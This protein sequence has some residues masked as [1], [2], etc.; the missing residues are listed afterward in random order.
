MKFKRNKL[1]G[2]ISSI[3][4]GIGVLFFSLATIQYQVITGSRAEF[5]GT[6]CDDN[7]GETL[8]SS[9]NTS[10]NV[11]CSGDL[12]RGFTYYLFFCP[13]KQT[14]AVTCGDV[15]NPNS[16]E[17]ELIEENAGT[18]IPPVMPKTTNKSCGC[19][20]WNVVVTNGDGSK[21]SA[22][23]QLLCSE[24]Q[25]L[26]EPTNTPSPTRPITITPTRSVTSTPTTEPIAKASTT[27]SPTTPTSTILTPTPT[28]SVTGTPTKAPIA[29]ANATV[30]PATPTPIP[31][32]GA[33]TPTTVPP[34]STLTPTLTRT[35]TPTI[36]PPTPSNTP[37]YTPTRTP[38]PTS[39]STP[40]PILTSAVPPT[41]APLNSS[42]AT[43]I[44]TPVTQLTVNDQ[45]PGFNP[46]V[47]L[48]IP[49]ALI[50]AGLA[51]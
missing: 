10:F 26:I 30:A 22:G 18:V 51:L 38:T 15:E 25:C 45:P 5:D 16:A 46:W 21:G 6:A 11:N 47:A 35:P 23:G 48:F 20:Q 34:T 41:N 9:G 8:N 37:S 24:N 27:I 12:A 4:F 7:I 50:V 2:I 17:F 28:R 36:V 3:F 49:F 1:L 43:Q 44:P 42:Q 13:T 32:T 31:T 19:V 40:T 39:T 33:G 14:G 29:K